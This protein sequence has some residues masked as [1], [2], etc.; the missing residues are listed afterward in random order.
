MTDDYQN[1][2]GRKSSSATIV[3]PSES[4]MKQ[5]P[6]TITI[7]QIN[8]I[9]HVTTVPTYPKGSLRH[10]F[11]SLIQKLSRT[12]AEERQ[13][14]KEI[15]AYEEQNQQESVGGKNVAL[16]LFT[17][18]RAVDDEE[19]QAS[20]NTE[21]SNREQRQRNQNARDRESKRDGYYIVAIASNS[22]SRLLRTW[23]IAGFMIIIGSLIAAA[24]VLMGLKRST[25]STHPHHSSIPTAKMTTSVDISTTHIV[26]TSAVAT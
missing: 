24:F 6:S 5:E 17:N 25:V 11:Y 16:K 13:S 21:Y 26:A 10:L 2:N 8:A 22:T 15:N 7:T 19:K 12:N 1:S 9:S 14:C 20:K 23:L 3:P 4:N 18:T